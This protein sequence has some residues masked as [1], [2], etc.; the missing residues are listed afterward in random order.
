MKADRRRGGE[1]TERHI[2]GAE[3]MRKRANSDAIQSS[4]DQS[5]E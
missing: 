4:L 5:T 2:A 3:R 1:E